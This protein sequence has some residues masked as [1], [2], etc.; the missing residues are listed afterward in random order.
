MKRQVLYE[1]KK[2][3]TDYLNANGAEYVRKDGQEDGV[4]SFGYRGLEI[5]INI[6][7]DTQ[8]FWIKDGEAV[9]VGK[10]ALSYVNIVKALKEWEI[11]GDED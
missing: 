6:D 7:T 9:F 4:I 10:G 11:G 2:R 5:I 3:L 8:S 1:L